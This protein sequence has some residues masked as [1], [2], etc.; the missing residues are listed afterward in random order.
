MTEGRD[1]TLLA[2][3]LKAS[4]EPSDQS[5]L[6]AMRA[7]TKILELE[8]SIAQ[9]Q[10]G[11]CLKCGIGPRRETCAYPEA[12][13]HPGRVIS[14][15]RGAALI[16]LAQ[17]QARIGEL[18]SQMLPSF[19]S[20]HRERDIQCKT[21]YPDANALLQSHV[22]A[23]DETRRIVEQQ[24]ATIRELEKDAARLNWC[25]RDDVRSQMLY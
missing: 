22:E 14:M 20:A 12:C 15:E 1:E 3:L 18:E 5:C 11:N 25:D 16:E 2:D 10:A 17:A 24:A 19:C 7:R 4:D 13:E 6:L 21:C 9:A 23:H 8:R